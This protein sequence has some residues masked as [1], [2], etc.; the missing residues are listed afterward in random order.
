MADFPLLKTG[1]VMQYPAERRRDYAT[2]VLEFLDGGEQ[3]F[4]SQPEPL[5]Q[6]IIRLDLL[7]EGELKALENFF[8]AQAGRQQEFTFLDPWTAEEVEHC[9]FASD[10]LELSLTGHDR[11]RATLTIRENRN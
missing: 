2:R 7:Q 11:G 9:S 1:A 8:R 10:T 4:R 5:R 6:W 3:R